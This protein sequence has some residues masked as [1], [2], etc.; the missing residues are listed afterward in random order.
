MSEHS[1]AIIKLVKFKI[2]IENLHEIFDA[3]K[4]T[5]DG[6][7]FYLKVLSESSKVDA[8]KKKLLIK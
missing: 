4:F 8:I 1:G 2:V 3:F 5:N 6:H 7:N